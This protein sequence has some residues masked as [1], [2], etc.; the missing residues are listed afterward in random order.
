MLIIKLVNH[1]VFINEFVL[2]LQ[3]LDETPFFALVGSWR[4]QSL[5]SMTSGM[6]SFELPSR[7]RMCS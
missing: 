2:P 3:L 5:G 7:S 6:K 4:A 1:L